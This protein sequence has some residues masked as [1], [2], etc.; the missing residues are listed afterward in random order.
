M[1]EGP[2]ESAFAVLRSGRSSPI[3]WRP[4]AGGDEDLAGM[5]YQEGVGA[6]EW[7]EWPPATL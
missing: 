7:F 2:P 5:L 6:A 4:P 1:T 3:H